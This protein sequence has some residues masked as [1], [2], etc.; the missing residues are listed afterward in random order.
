MTTRWPLAI[1]NSNQ[2]T[3]PL[4]DARSV[5]HDPVLVEAAVAHVSA[6]SG[7]KV[8]ASDASSVTVSSRLRTRLSDQAENRWRTPEIVG[9]RGGVTVTTE[10]SMTVVVLGLV[11][12]S[13]PTDTVT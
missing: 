6:T 8:A 4:P 7:T 5:R 12:S 13:S 2:S 9:V 1:V 11:A 3:S 10:L